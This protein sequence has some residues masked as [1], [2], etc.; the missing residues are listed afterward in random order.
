M[1]VVVLIYRNWEYVHT[2]NEVTGVTVGDAGISVSEI[3]CNSHINVKNVI[4]K[5]KKC[6]INVKNVI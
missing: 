4:Y 1:V 6:Y 2:I 5:C 3:C